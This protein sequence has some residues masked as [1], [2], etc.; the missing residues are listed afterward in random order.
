MS[1]AMRAL[2]PLALA[3]CLSIVALGIVI[4]ILP[5]QLRALG[6]SE[7][8]TPVIFTVYS[9]AAFVSAPLWGRLSDRIGRKPVLLIAITASTLSYLW[10]ASAD[11]MW[12]VFAARLFAGATSGWLAAS[13][14]FVA[15]V[16]DR[17]GRARG[18]AMLG[19][20]F[21]IGFTI[22]PLTGAVLAG[23]DPGFDLPA[24]IAA[25]F[26][27]GAFAIVALALKEP[28][29][30]RGEAG[31][32]VLKVAYLRDPLLLRLMTI[33]FCMGFVFTAVEGVFA[34]WI[35]RILALG[36]REV[37]LYLA[38]TGVV[39][40]LVQGA[41]GRL[42]ARFG[43]LPLLATGV[44]AFSA[45]L[46]SFPFVTGPWGVLVPMGLIAVGVGL[47]NPTAQ[48]LI[49]R[50]APEDRKGGVL[51]TAQSLASLARIL[52]PA[53]GG[54]AFAGLAPNAPFWIGLMLLAP[55]LLLVLAQRGRVRALGDAGR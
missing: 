40:I 14:A 19:I 33:Y 13:Q 48:S 43:E 49:S 53:L 23:V 52:G 15:D 50:A 22:G 39:T 41:V 2:W 34:I 32:E 6:A 8:M 51:G 36:A 25:G 47:H 26:T 28:A 21:G 46:L 1:P 17:A 42:A 4:P 12:E 27:L 7:A 24:L 3:T 37:G 38:Y 9:A 16:T 55:V 18:M 5:F 29:R 45:G 10:L 54:Q 44:S 35:E 30:H 11:Q 20:A 31:Q